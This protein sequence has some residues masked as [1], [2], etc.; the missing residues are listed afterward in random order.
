[1][2]DEDP[3]A[4]PI[5]GQVMLLVGAK[6]SVAPSRLPDLLA[7]A[8]A[9]LADRREDYERRYERV[10]E[11]ADAAYFLVESG[12]WQSIRDDLGVDEREADAVRR[13]HDQQ[14]LREGRRI[15]RRDEFGTALDVR[16]SVVIGG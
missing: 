5:E 15:D 6:A 4:V 10:H 9:Y 13:A 11:T 3:A 1:M 12:H 14:L 7:T 2:G 8:Q 16:E